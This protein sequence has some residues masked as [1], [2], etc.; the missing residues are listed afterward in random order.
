[1]HE[2]R[3]ARAEAEGVPQ[4]GVG[5]THP[6][7]R[8]DKGGRGGPHTQNTTPPENAPPMTTPK[9]KAYIED[10]LIMQ[11][12]GPPPGSEGQSV[13][14]RAAQLAPYALN[15]LAE[16]MFCSKDDRVRFNAADTI[17]NRAHGRPVAQKKHPKEEVAQMSPEQRLR[18]F[19]AAAD[20]ERRAI[21]AL[22][23]S[24]EDR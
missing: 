1:M 7:E 11:R 9:Q 8:A 10:E 3:A 17:L 16:L 12:V 15:L 19:E 21:A 13:Q 24:G 23:E 18:A 4:G 22:A 2:R 14:Q 20:R 5:D 6:R